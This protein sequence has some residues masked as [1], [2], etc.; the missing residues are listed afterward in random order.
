[1]YVTLKG[2]TI[3]KKGEAKGNSLKI[4]LYIL[5]LT[6]K[7]KKKVLGVFNIGFLRDRAIA[8]LISS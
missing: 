8:Y 2:V 4:I 7:S 6:M 1:M 3:C 5:E